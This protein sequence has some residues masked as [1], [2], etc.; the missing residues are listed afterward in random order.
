MASTKKYTLHWTTPI[1]LKAIRAHREPYLV[2]ILEKKL[3]VYPNVLSPLYD[4]SGRFHVENLPDVRGKDFLEIGCGSG[5]IS[6]FAH[7]NGA[8]SVTA[9]D[10]NP[11]AVENT[12]DN[13]QRYKA[14]NCRAYVSDVFTN[15]EGKY[16]V[17][18]FNA[19][20]HGTAPVDLLERSVAD[21]GYESLRA[22][23]SQATQYLQPDGQIVLGFS[24]SG[25][26]E[27][28]RQLLQDNS[29]GVV[30]LIS[31]TRQGYNCQIYFLEPAN[32]GNMT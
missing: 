15:V 16:D 31:D 17:I 32:L 20:Y 6:I 18:L 11:A 3:I 1:F 4:W 23:L 9:V 2:D 14:S 26:T 28:L 27:M 13:F 24:E 22:F 8:K 10:I 7:L 19:P 30:Q 25:D 5:L 21:A 29:L 12:K